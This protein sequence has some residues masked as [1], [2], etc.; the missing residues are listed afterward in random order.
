[1]QS[2]YIY[3]EEDTNLSIDKLVFTHISQH[4]TYLCMFQTMGL[5]QHVAILS[6]KNQYPYNPNPHPFTQLGNPKW[7]LWGE[8]LLSAPL[9]QTIALLTLLNNFYLN[10]FLYCAHYCALY[11]Y[12]SHHNTCQTTCTCT[13]M[14]AFIGKGTLWHCWIACVLKSFFF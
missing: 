6:G 9:H 12:R 4:A 1:M 5:P 7:T 2:I 3:F 10:I 8:I 14:N 11:T 13:V